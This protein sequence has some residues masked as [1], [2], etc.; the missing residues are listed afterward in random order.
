MFAGRE[1]VDEFVA[2]G[3]DHVIWVPDSVMGLWETAFQQSPDLDLVRVCREGEAWPLAAGL[4][5]GGAKPIVLINTKNYFEP[6]LKLI[7]HAIAHDFSNASIKELIT[8]VDTP[9]EAIKIFAARR[10]SV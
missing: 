6:L 2:L 5:I 7:E 3:I 8:V 4:M 1:I 10:A 9:E